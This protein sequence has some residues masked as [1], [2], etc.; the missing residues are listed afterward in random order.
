MLACGSSSTPPS[1]RKPT[2]DSG[3]KKTVITSTQAKSIL[4]GC[5]SG[6]GGTWSNS[7]DHCVSPDYSAFSAC[8]DNGKT[9][10]RFPSGNEHKLNANDFV[11]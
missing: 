1:D 3:P 7:T 2:A 4:R 10:I 8:A 6:A 9:Y 5:C 11:R